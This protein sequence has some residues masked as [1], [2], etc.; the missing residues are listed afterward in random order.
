MIVLPDLTVGSAEECQQWK[1]Q[2]EAAHYLDAAESRSRLDGY[3]ID[4]TCRI[5]V[6]SITHSSSS[7]TV[8]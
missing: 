3:I 4:D 7:K 6:D 2:V 1:K 8:A 5:R